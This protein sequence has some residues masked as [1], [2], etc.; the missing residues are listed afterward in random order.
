MDLA[1]R[2]L[3]WLVGLQSA[4]GA[5]RSDEMLPVCCGGGVFD[6]DGFARCTAIADLAERALFWL[7]NLPSGVGA[8]LKR[9]DM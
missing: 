8:V 6:F 4:I 3:F 9:L 5:V 2:A 7:I 1:V